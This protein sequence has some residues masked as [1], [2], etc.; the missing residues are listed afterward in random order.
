MRVYENATVLQISDFTISKPTS[1]LLIG[2][3]LKYE[4][5]LSAFLFTSHDTGVMLNV[6]RER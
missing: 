5:Y 4:T 1:N 6:K 3:G 2:G